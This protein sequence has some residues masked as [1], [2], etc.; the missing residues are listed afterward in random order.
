VRTL[1][2]VALWWVALFWLWELYAGEMNRQTLIAAAIV[3]SIGAAVAERLR[4][5]RLLHFRV[6]MEWVRRSATVPLQIFLDFAIITGALFR[7]RRGEFVRKPFAAGDR[8]IEARGARAWVTLALGFAPNAYVVDYGDG[9]ILLHDL[10][11]NE[12]SEKPA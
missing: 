11:R 3:A 1:G 7:P 12:A 4:R 6:P 2:F 5:L 10:V 8:E 9:E